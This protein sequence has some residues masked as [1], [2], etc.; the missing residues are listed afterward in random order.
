MDSRC[1]IAL[2]L[3]FPFE[4]QALRC[5]LR[6]QETL[7]V[8]FFSFGLLGNLAAAESLA[9][10]VLQLDGEIIDNGK[11]VK[12]SW[13]RASGSNVGRVSIQR[14]VLG[15]TGK[16]SWQSIGSL[17]SFARIYLDTE[18]QSGVAYEY[19]VSRPSKE[20]TETGYW[21][22]GLNLPVRENQGVALVVV[23]ETLV[24]DL[25]PR[26]DRFMLDLI[27]D[28]WT[29]VPHKV[30]R[31]SNRD[32]VANLKAARELRAW[33]QNRYNSAHY[34]PHALI[35][36]GRIP[37]V[38]SG[39]TAPD[40]HQKRPLESDLF[41]AEMNAL[42]QDNG[43]GLLLHDTIPSDHIEMQVGRIDFSN[44]DD[45]LGNE[46]T[47]L[48][49]YFDKNHHWRHGRLGDLREAYGD[50]GHLEVEIN[51]LG[52][53]V[54]P[55]NRVKGGHL[56]LGMQ[57]PWLLGVDYAKSKY[58]HYTSTSPIKTVF[59]INFGSG[60][61]D[62]SRHNNSLT[63][64]LAQAWY[65]L[66]TGWGSRPAWQLHH[67]ALGYSIGYSH[68]RTVNNGALSRGGPG[69]LEYT[70]TGRYVMIN[71]IWVNLLGDPTL[72]PFPLESVKN[73]RAEKLANSVQLN[74]AKADSSALIK[75][76]IY[77]AAKRSGPYQALNPLELLSGH[78]YV[79]TQPVS[80]AWYMV[81]AH[82]LKEVY[83]G[84][85]YTYAQGAFA[86][87][88]NLP[89]SATD[90]SLATPMGQALKIRLSGL[91]PDSDNQLTTA[92]VKGPEGG[93]LALSNGNWS[94][95][96]DAGFSGQVTIPF[97][98]FDGITS[99]DG[100]IDIDVLKP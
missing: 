79:D 4:I 41:Y 11:T 36:I 65:G 1:R 96:P 17:R 46:V 19:Q 97:T 80:G 53:I 86:T 90:Q 87:V 98:V 37:V 34:L 45:T 59:S 67:M 94:F 21:A 73:L 47:L 20:K 35:L 13:S 24:D 16:E 83:A 92:F 76:R 32:P 28:G 3:Y 74:W 14:R 55:G 84:S 33:I 51:A 5:Y 48:N 75:Y 68:L 89:P 93:R 44:L 27:G 91:D 54:G 77:R 7:L 63:A 99:A 25:A 10:G 57:Q 23:D 29:V 72:A 60:K 82:S 70:P 2:S 85:F 18:F 69:T 6:L 56:D 71:P 88:D 52:N 26:L 81:R 12:L 50:G 42:W 95:I 64:M 9:E 58:K 38:K 30:P 22:T 43:K 61:P 78:Q 8:C 49:R 39:Q 40:G 62:F 100:V 66:V 15:Q 31:G